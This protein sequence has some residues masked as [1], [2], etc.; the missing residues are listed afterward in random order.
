MS[1]GKPAKTE[2]LLDIHWP[3]ET[4]GGIKADG[5]IEGNSLGIAND[6][7]A[8]SLAISGMIEGANIDISGTGSFGVMDASESTI[9]TLYDKFGQKVT[10]GLAVYESA[11]IDPDTTLDHLILTN[12]NTPNGDFMYIKTEFYSGKSAT[13]N[14]VQT[15]LPYRNATVA[16]TRHYYDNAWSDWTILGGST[17]STSELKTGARWIDGKPIYRKTIHKTFTSTTEAGSY[18]VGTIE[19]FGTPVDVRGFM[20]Q[21]SDYWWVLPYS[22]YNSIQWS[23]SLAF[24]QAGSLMLWKG[25]YG[26]LSEVYAIVEYTKTTD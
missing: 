17:Y 9:D 19:N 13:A 4:E 24:T 26:T 20:K 5:R 21:G 7:E 8:S 25:S 16:Y 15:A 11:G 6:I 23:I 18:T 1:I 2:N 14:R 3:I 10:N 12:K 22:R